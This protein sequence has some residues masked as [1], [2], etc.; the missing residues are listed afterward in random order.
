MET[1]YGYDAE[2]FEEILSRLRN[3]EAELTSNTNFVDSENGLGNFNFSDLEDLNLDGFN[4]SCNNGYTRNLDDV[5]AANLGLGNDA[6]N[7]DLGGDAT[8]F[9]LGGDATNFGLGSDTA[10]FD[11]GSDTANFGLGS[12]DNCSSR[13]V[14]GR[15]CFEKGLREGLEQGFIRGFNRGRQQGREEGLREGFSRGLERGLS[16]SEEMAR[17]AFQRGFR[18]GFEKG[19]R[20]GYQ[21]G[22]RDGSRSGF[23]RG[24][25]VGFNRG[26]QRALRDVMRAVNNLACNANGV[27]IAS[28]G[29]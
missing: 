2:N 8:N 10:N 19:F 9:D 24:A 21:K 27:S 16:R 23:E 1:N 6:A 26:Y 17:A 15:E 5:D 28:N 25:R 20:T 18:C 22:F 29:N 11:L 3:D 12:N 4:S 13:V 14:N 7:F